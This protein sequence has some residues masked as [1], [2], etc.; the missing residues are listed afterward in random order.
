MMQYRRVGKSR[1]RVSSIGFGTCQLRLVTEQQAINTLKRGFDLGVNIEP[2]AE[3]GRSGAFLK[4]SL[5]R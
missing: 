2:N 5:Y 3:I 1:L 4:V